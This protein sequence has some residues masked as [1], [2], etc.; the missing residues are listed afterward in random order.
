MWP[1]TGCLPLASIHSSICPPACPSVPSSP[2]TRALPGALTPPPPPTPP[3]LPR[4]GQGDPDPVRRPLDSWLPQVP[5]CRGEW[6]GA[7]GTGWDQHAPRE[8]SSGPGDSDM[9]QK[10]GW[11]RGTQSG[12]QEVARPPSPPGWNSAT[13]TAAPQRQEGGS[14]QQHRRI[15]CTAVWAQE[16]PEYTRQAGTQPDDRHRH[17]W[18]EP[19]A[20]TWRPASWVRGVATRCRLQARPVTFEHLGAS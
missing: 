12:R 17:T 13:V 14:C 3:G 8:P 9:A 5:P 6:G 16:R 10:R 1:W 15:R 11:A 2:L 4:C 20:E 18:G 19:A 7:W